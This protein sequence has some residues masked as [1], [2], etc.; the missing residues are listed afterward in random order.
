MVDKRV[1]TSRKVNTIK[2]NGNNT[3]K[4]R[5]IENFFKRYLMIELIFPYFIFRKY[6]GTSA[7]GNK[8][9]KGGFG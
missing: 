8:G 4:V 3:V 1:I 7:N 5:V 9:G 6:S 2:A